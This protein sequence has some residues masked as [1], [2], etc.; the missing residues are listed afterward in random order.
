MKRGRETGW[1]P[2]TKI[3]RLRVGLSL[4]WL[5]VYLLLLMAGGCTQTNVEEDVIPPHALKDVEAG[6]NLNVLANQAPIARSMTFTANGT[7]ETDTLVAGANDTIRTRAGNPLTEVLE[8]QIASLWVGQYDATTGQRLFNQYLPSMTGTTVNL[9]LKQSHDGSRS[10]VY[11][12]SNA[13]DLGAISDETTLKR[14]ILEYGSTDVGLPDNNLCKMT[15]MWEG[16]V[17]EGGTK[18][19]TVNLMRLL[20]RITFT[21]S[22]GADFTFTPTSVVLKN[23]PTVSQVEAPTTQLMT[24]GISYKTY[25]GI[26]SQSGATVYWYL[27]ENMA[28]T[29]SG[30]NAVDFEKKKTG[31]GV[32]NATCI[33]LTGD[34]VQGGVTYK[35][36]T[37]RFYPGSNHNNYD[38]V[39]NS[40]YTMTVKLIGI[41]VSDERITV[42]E[43][44]PVEV[45]PTEMP[46]KK[47]GEKEIQITTRPGRPWEFDMPAWLSALL[48]GKEIP[49][50]ATITYQGPANVVFRSV[51][52]NPKAERRGPR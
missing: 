49:S 20:A 23:A 46:A 15:G 12:V 1:S 24:G 41:D 37:F 21:Y 52:A 14:H 34:A 25:T 16:V 47:G 27:P 11:F 29:V 18:D 13:G 19:I 17:Q 28:G 51:E 48:D 6:F 26:A 32:T 3:G 2:L 44:P 40:H 43:I 5:F 10:H 31:K 22:M 38:I 39:R 33:E 4:V 35:D 42:G 30:G 50:G 45:D 8:S 7:I 36:V 9:K